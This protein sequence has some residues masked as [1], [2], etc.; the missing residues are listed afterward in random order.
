MSDLAIVV[1]VFTLVAATEADVIFL[2]SSAND[3]RGVGELF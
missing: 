2:T 1:V 3:E